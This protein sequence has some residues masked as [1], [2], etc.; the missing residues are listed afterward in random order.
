VWGVSMFLTPT[1]PLG[2][3]FFH[4][5]LLYPL[6]ISKGDAQRAD[7]SV[8]PVTPGRTAQVCRCGALV[9]MQAGSGVAP[10]PCGTAGEEPGRVHT[11]PRRKPPQAVPTP[12]EL[13]G[14]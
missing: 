6:C 5:L 3:R 7:E 10:G 9:G 14:Q 13:V 11:S 2:S 4:T 1:V 8:R 12:E